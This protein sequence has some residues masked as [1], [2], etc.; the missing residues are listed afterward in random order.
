MDHY[1]H[2]STKEREITMVEQ[3]KAMSVRAIARTL[4]RSPSTISR[5]LRRN[6]NRDGSYSASA[7]NISYLKRRAA[8]HRPSIFANQTARAYVEELIKRKWSPEQIAGRAKLDGYPIP[9]SYSSIYRGIDHKLIALTDKHDLRLKWHYKRRKARKLTKWENVIGIHERPEEVNARTQFGH[10]ESDT[11]LGQRKTG[12]F[13]THVE[14]VTGFLIASRLHG[15]SGEEYADAMIDAFR[16]FPSR[17]RRSF[18]VD[19]GGEFTRHA[20]IATQL[21]AKVYFCDPYS[22]WQ[23]GTNENTN[24]LL[25]Q[26]FP[27]KSSF[28]PITPSVLQAAVDSLNDRP[29]KRLGWLSPRELF[30]FYLLHLV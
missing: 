24:G 23:K 21:N 4:G 9:F 10:W 3:G 13:A 25:R 26:Y 22:S 8:C 6:Q 12:G 7:A 17:S 19:R 15:G 29:R 14:R 1:R 16:D 30:S 28:L 11:V 5:E 27:K 18:T 20:R 2:L